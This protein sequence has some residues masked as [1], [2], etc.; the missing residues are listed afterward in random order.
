M[1][2][3]VGSAGPGIS[4]RPGCFASTIFR[5]HL[6]TNRTHKWT[7]MHLPS[8][9][10]GTLNVRLLRAS[11]CLRSLDEARVGDEE[12][13]EPREL[14]RAGRIGVPALG[15]VGARAVGRI[16]GTRASPALSSCSR[17]ARSPRLHWTHWPLSC[18]NTR[19]ALHPSIEHAP[20]SIRG[21]TAR[22]TGSSLSTA[23]AWWMCED[24]VNTLVTARGLPAGAT[25]PSSA[26][27]DIGSPSDRPRPIPS[28]AFEERRVDERR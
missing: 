26:S 12:V 21:V 5:A 1:G 25:I 28:R 18:T 2:A 8:R 24:V 16:I 3:G 19:N 7:L 9:L 14:D 13:A 20:G 11:L 10:R 17:L 6:L 15:R 22:A 23:A 4:P 27:G